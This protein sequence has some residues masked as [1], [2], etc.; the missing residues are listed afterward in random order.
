[1]SVD[2]RLSK[3]LM[4]CHDE[5]EKKRCPLCKSLDTKKHRFLNSKILTVRGIQKRKI[6]RFLCKNCQKSFTSKRYNR[7]QKTSVKN[8]LPPFFL[9][10]NLL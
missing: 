4:W 3:G 8:K 7:R 9:L 10:I 5:N 6:Q 1:M 2:K